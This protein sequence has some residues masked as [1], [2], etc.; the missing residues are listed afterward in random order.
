MITHRRKRFYI[1]CFFFSQLTFLFLVAVCKYSYSGESN[2]DFQTPSKQQFKNDILVRNPNG[3]REEIMNE[4]KNSILV[5]KNTTNP[6]WTSSTPIAVAT[7]RNVKKS[8]GKLYISRIKGRENYCLK[9]QK[10]LT[11]ISK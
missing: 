11:P 10:R 6:V 1:F 5:G 4:E 3:K 8:I 7:L 9:I 2:K